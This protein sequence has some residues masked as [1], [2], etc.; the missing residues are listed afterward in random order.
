MQ[1][2]PRGTGLKGKAVVSK[3]VVQVTVFTIEDAFRQVNAPSDHIDQQLGTGNWELGTGIVLLQWNPMVASRP[4]K[5]QGKVF[6]R[7]WL[8]AGQIPLLISTV[9]KL[10]QQQRKNAG[11]SAIA[12]VD[13]FG[14]F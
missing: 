3:S 4:Y 11:M 8:Y 1:I 13:L 10:P 5:N 7:H 6:L 2:E 9:D 12:P 14:G